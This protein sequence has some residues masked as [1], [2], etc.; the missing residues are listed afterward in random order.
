MT[1]LR[2]PASTGSKQGRF[3]RGR[4]GNPRGRPAGQRHRF[5]AAM[6]LI[7]EGAA[8]AVLQTV[9]E[10]A[11]TGDLVACGLIL[12]RCWPARK[13]RLVTLELP[14]IASAADLPRAIGALMSAVAGGILTPDEALPVS[15]LLDGYRRAIETCEL[16]ARIAA[17]EATQ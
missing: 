13:G 9:I 16:E 12:S 2:P 14:T 15:T 8:A 5:L 7:G 10:A 6:D 11:Q 3:E 17:L 4:S 1:E